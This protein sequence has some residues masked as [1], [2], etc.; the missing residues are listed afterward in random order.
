MS[1]IRL[2]TY[3]HAVSLEDKVVLAAPTAPVTQPMTSLCLG[4]VH[5]SPLSS[6]LSVTCCALVNGTETQVRRVEVS[7]F[8]RLHTGLTM[9]FW[10]GDLQ[11]RG[12]I[13]F[14]GHSGIFWVLASSLA[15]FHT[16]EVVGVAEAASVVEVLA[17]L[18]LVVK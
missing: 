7:Y 6:L 15:L 1:G 18:T 10:D 9:G 2:H 17:L 12:H 3:L 11:F 5:I 13:Q 16:L 14:K 8:E 4:V